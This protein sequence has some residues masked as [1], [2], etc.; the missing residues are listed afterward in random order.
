MARL[1]IAVSGGP[2]PA[3][4]VNLLKLAERLGYESG[5]V[6]EGHGGDQ[7]AVLSAVTACTSTI[8]LGTAIS[9]VYVRT[10]PT[11][12][13]AAATLDDISGGRFILGLGS[14]H[15]VQVEP[16]HGV[17]YGKSITRTRETVA[18]IRQLLDE[19]VAKIDGD[20]IR[21]E[22]FDLWF[23][24]SGRYMPIYLAGLFPK[25]VEATG[26]IADGIILTRSILKTAASARESLRVG[27]ERAGR[28]PSKIAVTSLMPLAVS[29]DS[30]EAFARMRPGLAFYV[31]FFLRYNR[32]IAEH[33]FPDEVARIREAWQRGNQREAIGM[34]T[35]AMIDATGIAGTPGECKEKIQA[36]RESGIDLPILSPFAR[37]PAA[38]ATFEFAIRACA[39]D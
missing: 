11:I 10:P 33:G 37:G 27:A 39:P 32:L 17:Q 25:M 21:I 3:E 35:D 23:E 7:F 28:D 29:D 34:V 12:A 13:M 14:S 22:N 36:Y 9:S 1:G 16:E 26:E 4:I 6:A 31:G 20:T 30:A 24:R 19:G 5:W 38:N 8:K 2:R 18:F 15:K